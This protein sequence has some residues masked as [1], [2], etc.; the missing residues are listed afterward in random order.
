MMTVSSALIGLLLYG[1]KN[2]GHA[3]KKALKPPHAH[4]FRAHAICPGSRTLPN[5]SAAVHSRSNQ[6]PA[7][8]RV[9]GTKTLPR[10]GV[11]NLASSHSPA[12]APQRGLTNGIH[13]RAAGS[14]VRCL[15][16][17]HRL[18][19]NRSTRPV[20][21]AR[22]RNCLFRDKWNRR[23]VPAGSLENR[24]WLGRLV[25]VTSQGAGRGEEQ[26]GEGGAGGFIGVVLEAFVFLLFAEGGQAH[27][28]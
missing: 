21:R 19:S 14:S 12:T 13:L 4:G 2:P 11:Q 15:Q 17:C 25:S 23:A 26:D 16:V 22:P 27:K 7:A 24:W 9:S 18:L 5:G 10:L 1:F 28:G 8:P 6:A 20:L 3:T